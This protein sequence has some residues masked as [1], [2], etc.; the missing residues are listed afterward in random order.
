MLF[1]TLGS[2]LEGTSNI[3]GGAIGQVHR[4]QDDLLDST[5]LSAFVPHALHEA[6]DAVYGIPQR[7]ILDAGHTTGAILKSFDQHKLHG[8][9]KSPN[10]NLKSSK[11]KDKSK[12]KSKSKS[13]KK[14]SS[15]GKH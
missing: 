7:T 10:G 13:D 11:N 4:T 8:D 15:K 14:G 12:S 3:A 1:T 2:L 5:G 6:G 9:D